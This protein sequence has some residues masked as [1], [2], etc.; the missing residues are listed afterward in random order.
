MV[1]C[2][3]AGDGIGKRQFN[4]DVPPI[5]GDRCYA[6]HG[7]DDHSRESGLRLDQRR[8]NSLSCCILRNGIPDAG[9]RAG[10]D[11]SEAGIRADA[12]R[13]WC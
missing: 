8:G 13:L 4:R 6:C 7:P 3:H 1:T 5:S 2:C 12:C 10:V 9:Q 11:G